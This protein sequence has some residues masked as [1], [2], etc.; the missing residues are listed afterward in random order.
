MPCFIDK[1]VAVAGFK[2]QAFSPHINPKRYALKPMP[3]AFNPLTFL[4]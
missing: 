1:A 2:V 4:L 3:S